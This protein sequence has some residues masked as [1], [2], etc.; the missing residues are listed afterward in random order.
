MSLI[1]KFRLPLFALPVCLLVWTSQAAVEVE[2]DAVVEAPFN[3]ATS[4]HES[5]AHHRNVIQD[6]IWWSV[7]GREMAWMHKNAHSLFPTVTVYRNGPVRMLGSEP[8][9][10]IARFPVTTPEGPVPFE[11]FIASE[12]STAMGIVV[13]QGGRIVFERYPRMQDYEKP[14]YWS[15]AK[16]LPAT[17]IGIL[18]GRGEVDV[19]RPIGGY[20]PELATSDFAAISVRNLLDMASGLD[21]EDEY[22]DRRSCYYRYSMA[23]GDGIRDADAPDNPYEFLAGLKVSK[24]ADPGERYSYSGVNTFLLGWLVEKLTGVPFQDA[25]TREIWWHIGA[26]ADASF[27]AYRYGIPLTHGGLLAKPR[28]L[29][30][31]GLLFTPSY[32]VVSARRIIP[33]A[34]IERLRFDSNPALRNYAESGAVLPA[35]GTDN[36]HAAR[37]YTHSAYQWDY[38]HP[39]GTLF[40][41]GWGG[42]GLIVN[43]VHDLVV[44][45]ASF[46]KDDDHSE[47]D[48]GDAVM[49]MLN[50]VYGLALPLDSP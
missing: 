50:G 23:I 44:V 46:F 34:H 24:H 22:E 19:S 11:A 18:E 31:F 2:R 40:K 20:L 38:V 41:G 35:S 42:Q 6:D 14:I 43:P 25:F 30:R 33:P 36:S 3:P 21:C 28:D 16:V 39:D 32:S 4:W 48:L 49:E 47:M 15:V 37:A 45:F 13:V 9:A 12:R 26:E 7:T 1:D 10:E 5:L 8:S 17:V 27:I 29:A